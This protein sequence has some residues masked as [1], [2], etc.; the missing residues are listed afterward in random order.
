MDKSIL[1]LGDPARCPE[2]ALSI[3]I[4]TYRGENYLCQAIDS[5]LDQ[6]GGVPYEVVVVS[7][8]PDD[9][10]TGIAERY[11]DRGNF[12]LYRNAENIG[13]VGNSNRCA[14]LARGEYIAF[15]HDDDYLLPNYLQVV[16]SCVLDRGGLP[17]L[18]TGRYVEYTG[19]VPRAERVRKTLRKLYFVP[20]LYR[21]RIRPVRLEDSLRSGGNIYFS[22]SCGTVIRRDVF[23]SLGGF[24]ASIPYS[25][26]LDF[27]LRLNA[28]WELFETTEMCAVYR[29]G[30]NASLKGAVKYDFY[31][32]FRGRYLDLMAAN[33]VDPAY[34]ARYRKAFLHTIARQLGSGLEPE[35]E[36]RG[37]SVEKV[38]TAERLRYRLTTL[39]YY[40]NH[41]LDV[42]RLR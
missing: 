26:D 19:A 32:F 27:F 22:P 5:A 10:L 24:D 35:L 25:F 6:K 13:M 39:L 42:Q 36:K 15:L 29:I 34:L 17:C 2:P 18:I 9:P 7:N 11:R 41:N 14:E 20:D 33:A 4:P 28:A 23:R 40:Y 30:D 8:D 1:I 37:E 21:K 12:F 16:K 3:L 31:D 38:G